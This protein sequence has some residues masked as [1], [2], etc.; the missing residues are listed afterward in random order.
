MW[1]V[2]KFSNGTASNRVA[3]PPEI[4]DPML[5][6]YIGEGGVAEEAVGVELVRSAKHH[7]RWLACECRGAAVP[8]P[9]LSPAYMTVAQ[10][11]Y[12]RR[13]TGTG[14][15]PH[16]PTC[17]FHR[18]QA[19]YLRD[20]SERSRAAVTPPQGYF[21]V[22][23]PL[24]EHLAQ[25]TASQPDTRASGAS[26]P[27]LAKLLWLLIQRAG[28]DTV[29][30]IGNRAK[31]SLA[32]EFQRLKAAA[33]NLE[34]APGILLSRFLFTHPEDFRRRRIYAQLREAAPTWPSG[35][36]PGAFLLLYAKAVTAREIILVEGEPIL[37]A[38]DISKPPR[39]HI[40]AGPYLVLV[41]IGTDQKTKGYAALS[42]YAQPILNGHHFIPV[43]TTRER[44]LLALVLKLQWQLRDAGIASVI[45]KPTFDVDTPDGFCRPT[46]I[47]DMQHHA[48][49]HQQSYVLRLLGDTGNDATDRL[50]INAR[51]RS[52]GEVIEIA[53]A[54]LDEPDLLSQDLCAR[55]TGER[56]TNPERS[57][58]SPVSAPP[59]AL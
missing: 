15:P 17:P 14:R 8:P 9:L 22:L 55:M 35:H 4:H 2:Q 40:D 21:A 50:L 38:S 16:D 29:G 25:K 11:Y 46:I 3:I 20:R 18:D 42:A 36:E 39:K 57:D 58:G 48:D 27:R 28:A 10:T 51:L 34:I 7:D 59:R 13:L 45:E 26:I 6:W 33:A 53:A 5:R 19:D 30:A 12:L 54:W 23:A 31:P 52:I 41:A 47:L 1:L 49:R 44:Q 56:V 24:R 37:V 43:Q 32:L